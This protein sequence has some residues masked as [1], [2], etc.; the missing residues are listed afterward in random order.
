[1]MPHAFT[2][3]DFNFLI[4]VS[5]ASEF[6]LALFSAFIRKKE[7]VYASKHEK[8]YE[9]FYFIII[10]THIIPS[11]FSGMDERDDGVKPSSPFLQDEVF[12]SNP[13]S[14]DDLPQTVI[15]L[16]ERILQQEHSAVGEE[17]WPVIWDFSGRSL[18]HAMHPIFMSQEAVY[19]L[20]CDLSKELFK[21]SDTCVL[22]P[23]LPGHSG[24]GANMVCN[25]ESSLDHLMRWMDLVHSFQGSNKVT[26]S[27]ISQP[28]VIL[29]GTHADKVVGDP[30]IPMNAFLDSFHGKAFASHI[31]D[32]T[33]AVD[34]TR[35]GQSFQ[36]EDQNIQR[37]RQK[38]IAV[39]STLPHIQREI[40]LQWLYVEKVLHRLASN[41]VKHVTKAE[42]KAIAE[43]ICCFEV[44][45][46]CDTLLHFLCDCGALLCFN[47][48]DE[49]KTLVI[50]DPQ[51]LIHVFCQVISVVH[52]KKEPMAIREH[53]QNLAKR[54]ILSEDLVNSACETLGLKFSKEVLLSIMEKSNLVCRWDAPNGEAIYLVPSVLTAKPEDEI[55]GSSVQGSIAPVY[56]TFN[57]GY[58]PYGFFARFLMLFG[59]WASREHSAKSPKLF[60]NAARFFIGRQSEFSLMFACFKSVII[61]HLVHD[62]KDEVRETAAVCQQVCRLV[63]SQ[64][65]KVMYFSVRDTGK[66]DSNR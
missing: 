38:V 59:Q 52:R 28:P 42:F 66:H 7:N 51:W 5:T 16:V 64:T 1:M 39:A 48:A 2:L 50:L 32:E 11:L 57:T 61:V 34:N 10:Y 24:R 54:G 13:E 63:C 56:L 25:G 31:V 41:G 60:A 33:F 21:R 47:E 18:F 58:I 15:S 27:G 53:R 14:S 26:V 46:D 62:G 3:I 23:G 20:V 19:L 22:Q 4:F 49:S 12:V 6:D 43:R 55:S 36:Q 17:V 30:W 9:K 35:S 44:Q 8:Y 65:N 29:V 40:P 45:E 37:L